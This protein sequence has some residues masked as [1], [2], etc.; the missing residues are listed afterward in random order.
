M[1]PQVLIFDKDAVQYAGRLTP[2][3]PEMEFLVATTEVEAISRGTEASILVALAPP[4]TSRL[5]EN[6]PRLRWIQALTTG[7]DNLLYNMPALAPDVM[8][9]SVRGIHGPQMAE[10]AILYML[11]LSR[12]LRGF[13]AAQAQAQWL[14][15][16]QRL[17]AG[18][19]TV[20]VGVGAIAESLALR[21]KAFGMEV[22]G[23]SSHPRETAGFD[24]ML[25]RAA[26]IEA[27]AS[28]DFLVILL[29]YDKDTQNII[30]SAVIG[31]MKPD[32]VLI[33]LSR[34]RIVDEDALLLA[35][36]ENR[37]RGAG[38]DV[39]ATEPL[40]PDHPFWHCDNVILTP[41]I[42]GMSDVYAEQATP[43]LIENLRAYLAGRIDLMRNVVR[44]GEVNFK[45]LLE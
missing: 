26:L 6:M 13:F 45:F 42:G 25:P 35:L 5:I 22:V 15:K 29:P 38:L 28:A 32:A 11:A 14:R 39:F 40:P 3:L 1:K 30:D 23:I 7:T 20:L 41:H 12:D 19:R 27:A 2:L 10:L 43:A 34:G 18:R 44:P 24:Q 17:L 36:R 4:I 37:L 8:I 33:N 9:S 21:C 16:P 31:A